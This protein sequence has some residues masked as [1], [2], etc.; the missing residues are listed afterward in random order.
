[1]D[2]E[3]T[4][5]EQVLARVTSALAFSEDCEGIYTSLLM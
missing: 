4:T 3:T 5:L 2:E 1:M